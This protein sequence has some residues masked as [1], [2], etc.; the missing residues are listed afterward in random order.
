MI[1]VNGEDGNERAMFLNYINY[2][3]DVGLHNVQN[4]R[5]VADTDEAIFYPSLPASPCCVGTSAP[6]R[7]RDRRGPQ[8]PRSV[9]PCPVCKVARS[10]HRTLLTSSGVVTLTLA[11]GRRRRNFPL[12]HY[13]PSFPFL[14]TAL[15]VRVRPRIRHP[16]MRPTA[17]D[18]STDQRDHRCRNI[19][20]E[21]ILALSSLARSLPSSDFTDTPSFLLLHDSFN[22]VFSPFRDCSD[23]LLCTRVLRR[24]D[25][26]V[27]VV[28]FFGAN[29]LVHRGRGKRGTSRRSRN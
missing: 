15:G 19:F 10:A 11:P 6:P 3:G 26:R 13:S 16:Q 14:S 27:R 21:I 23:H 4:S 1:C 17:S 9:Y 12:C 22:C 7:R 20:V 24:D 25:R 28:L 2:N 8:K 18:R 5:V 29:R